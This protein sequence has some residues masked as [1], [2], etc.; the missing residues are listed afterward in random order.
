MIHTKYTLIAERGARCELCKVSRFRGKPIINL[1]KIARKDP[2]NK[3]YS[4]DNVLLVCANCFYDNG[5]NLHLSR[6]KTTQA[7]LS[8][9]RTSPV[10]MAA[11]G[12]KVMGIL[13]AC[14]RLDVTKTLNEGQE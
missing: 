1:L 5:Y 2:S 12:G 11:A 9:V 13:E 8:T 3:A 10:A 7:E 4:S 14:R 6:K